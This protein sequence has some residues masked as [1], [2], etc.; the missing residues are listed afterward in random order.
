M[1]HM[2]YLIMEQV[3]KQKKIQLFEYVYGIVWE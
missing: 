2:I 3:Q 1:V